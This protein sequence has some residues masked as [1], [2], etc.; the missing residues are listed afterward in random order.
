MHPKKFLPT[1]ETPYKNKKKKKQ[2]INLKQDLPHRL[3]LMPKQYKQAN[4]IYILIQKCRKIKF[5]S[6][7]RKDTAHLI[8]IGGK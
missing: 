4:N 3:T 1:H 2:T 7:V 8:E 5:T 6:Y